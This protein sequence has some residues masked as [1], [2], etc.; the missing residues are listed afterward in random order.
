MKLDDLMVSRAILDTYH[1]KLKSSL[2]VDVAVVGGG[3]AGLMAALRLAQKKIKV[4]L[5]E[6]KLSLGGGMWGGGIMFNKIVVQEEARSILKELGVRLQ[7]Y[8]K[9][10]YVAD[11]LETVGALVYQAAH[12][13][14]LIFNLMS[15]EDLK[16]DKNNIPN[17]LVINWSSV[18]LA[19]LHVDPITIGA[20]FILEATGHACEV[21]HIVLKRIGKKLTTPTGDIV[22]E[23]SMN[24]DV[25]ERAI[26]KNTKEFYH[27]IY[28][29]GMAANA[30][31]GEK[32]MGPIFGGMLLSGQKAASLVARRLGKSK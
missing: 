19:N 18:D 8:K 2:D 17:G 13:G 25:S 9:G 24:A 4:S 22:G 30:I 20:K 12:A 1:D 26:E 10:Y 6:R 27:N 7:P 5:Y 3:P 15:V 32:R 23:G 29:V 31:F 11:S 28:A 21:A 16:V 14:V